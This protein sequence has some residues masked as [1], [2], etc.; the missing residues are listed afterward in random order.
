MGSIVNHFYF[1]SAYHSDWHVARR[2]EIFAGGTELNCCWQGSRGKG[3]FQEG[4]VVCSAK[5]REQS[6]KIRPGKGLVP[7]GSVYLAV[8]TLV[9]LGRSVFTGTWGQNTVVCEKPRQG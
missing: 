2:Q 3:G 6:S 8:R 7:F 1:P 4:G 9:T 5:Y